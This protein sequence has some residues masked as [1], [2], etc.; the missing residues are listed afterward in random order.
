MNMEK[1]P[2]NNAIRGRE[3]GSCSRIVT[4][5]SYLLLTSGL[6]LLVGCATAGKA[7]V[8]PANSGIGTSLERLAKFV[9]PRYGKPEVSSESV[10]SLLE[11]ERPAPSAAPVVKGKAPAADPSSAATVEQGAD[12]A[13]AAEGNEHG[14]HAKE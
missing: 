4:I 9:P 13:R 3:H 7:K 11:I 1:A 10:A 8:E 14:T 5:G 2:N 12:A 6:S